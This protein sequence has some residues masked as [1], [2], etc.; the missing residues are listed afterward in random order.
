MAKD[1][2]SRNPYPDVRVSEEE[3][4]HLIALVNGCVQSHFQ[5]YDEFVVTDKHQ[6]D[7]RRWEHVKSKDD[8]HVYTERVNKDSRKTLPD[9]EKNMASMLSVGTFVGGLED[10]MFG[11]I[12]TFRDAMRVKTAYV[13]DV[14]N[15]AILCPVVEPTD[16]DPFR[17]LVV[18][19]MV[20][21][22][23]SNKCRDFVC[24]EATD[25]VQL[26]NGDRVGYH[27]LHS[28]EFPQTKPLPTMI[29]GNVSS[30]HFFR[31][32][33]RTIIDNFGSCFVDPGIKTKRRL[34]VSSTA[35]GMLTA[36]N[37]VRCGQM[38]KLA[39]ML[40]RH[41]ASF[42]VRE[43]MQQRKECVM[44]GRH[45][46]LPG[47]KKSTCKLCHGSVCYSCKVREQMSFISQE[48]E[49]VQ[50]KITFCSQ[51]MSKAI[52]CSTQEAARDQTMSY[53]SFGSS[54]TFSDSTL[55]GSTFADPT[56]SASSVS[57]DSFY[58]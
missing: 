51:C 32:I 10:L 44:C 43:E 46:S 19:W 55:L 49:L 57:E 50:H 26:D 6:V 35:K 23:S 37:Y 33:H 8:M 5:K 40:Q 14:D 52:N 17:T 13:G 20:T 16:D 11:I 47:I 9:A 38:K 21:D 2:F 39:W 41:Q 12:N 34:F 54:S 42:K 24:I 27:V 28:I 48:G 30:V 36:T 22:S 1:R 4:E 25:I 7:E 53:R 18:K 45:K 15:G 31:P 3:R 56:Y 58:Q 29:R